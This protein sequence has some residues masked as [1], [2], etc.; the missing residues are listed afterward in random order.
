[1]CPGHSVDAEEP[2]VFVSVIIH[3]FSLSSAP[4]AGGFAELS[5]CCAWPPP[6]GGCTKVVSA[7]LNPSHATIDVGGVIS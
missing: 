3:G 2:Q 1:M 6:C 7:R 5:S 4:T